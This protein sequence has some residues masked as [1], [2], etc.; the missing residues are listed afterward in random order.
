MLIKINA[1]LTTALAYV[2][3]DEN[4]FTG[5]VK[6]TY[7]QNRS[8][9]NLNDL[10]Y[11]FVFDQESLNIDNHPFFYGSFEFLVKHFRN[12]YLLKSIINKEKFIDKK[13]GKENI[14]LI[15][16]EKLNFHRNK[17]LLLNEVACY[18]PKFLMERIVEAKK[19]E[20]LNA[21]NS[22]IACHLNRYPQ[23]L[24]TL[25]FQQTELFYSG[26]K[27]KKISILEMVDLPKLRIF[28]IPFGGISDNMRELRRKCCS[29]ERCPVK[30]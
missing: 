18:L 24:R 20:L 30:I 10:C 17:M 15:P 16:I 6:V 19:L 11:R 3:Q 29:G 21:H 1:S 4:S 13:V 25:S 27:N 7:K 8:T 2:R 12:M 22:Q 26:K 5:Y 23:N 14:F 9:Y 28:R